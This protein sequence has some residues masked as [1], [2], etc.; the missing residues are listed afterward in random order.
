MTATVDDTDL[1]D[2]HRRMWASGNYPRMVE[3][4]LLPL[5]PRLVDACGVTGGTTVLDVASG[6]G[7][8]AL[9]AAARGARVT[10][11]DLTPEL[12]EAG[13]Q[14]AEAAGLALEWREAD[15]EHLP[16]ADAAYDVVMSSMASVWNSGPRH[17][18]GLA[19]A[20]EWTTPATGPISAKRSRIVSPD[21]TSQKRTSRLDLSSS[22]MPLLRSR[23]IRL[24]F[25]FCIV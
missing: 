12:L 9:P 24:N 20:M 13:R 14:R 25:S 7:N 1:K 3:T 22:V 6:T 10:A 21:V 17:V 15:A 4:F 5:G 2:R 23:K 8:A 11:S 16:F 19:Y 18:F